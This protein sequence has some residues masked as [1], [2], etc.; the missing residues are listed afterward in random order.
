MKQNRTIFSFL[1]LFIEMS[2]K[3]KFLL[4]ENGVRAEILKQETHFVERVRQKHY[5]V[6]AGILV[7]YIFL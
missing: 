7:S 5:N 6:C 4:V 2:N 3:I 1:H